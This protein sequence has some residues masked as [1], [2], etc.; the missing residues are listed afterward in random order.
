MREP[1]SQGPCVDSGNVC[2]PGSQD[3]CVE[4]S[5]LVPQWMSENTS[6]RL[7][8]PKTGVRCLPEEVWL[9]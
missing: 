4:S 7:P 3:T 6:T 8:G 5:M 1:G 2:E 9:S